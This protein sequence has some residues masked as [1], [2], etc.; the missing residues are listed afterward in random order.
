MFKAI[1]EKKHHESENIIT[2]WFRPEKAIHYLA[3]Q[4]T[5]LHLPHTKADDRGIKRWFTLSSS[6]TDAPLISI[7][8]KFA[9][10]SSSFKIKLKSMKVG[11]NV[12]MAEPMGDF[13][14]PKDK[15]IPLLFI[16]GGIGITPFHSIT[17]YLSDSREKR[18]IEL[19]YSVN[20]DSEI[21]FSDLW[22][23][24]KLS[25]FMSVVQNPSENWQGQKG[26]L[27]S[28]MIFS[29]IGDRNI[30]TYISG[31]EGMVEALFAELT[32]MGVSKNNLV[33]DYFPGYSQI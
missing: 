28:K 30:M 5:E 16:A 10:P 4:Y 25:D 18:D 31:P 13:V 33:G 9:H 27:D 3:G 11:D 1:L 8:T 26:R 15:S 20:Q 23:K 2:F 6:P 32:K 29:Q 19:I 17:K 24:Y 7:T 12:E 22:K 21:V 14:L